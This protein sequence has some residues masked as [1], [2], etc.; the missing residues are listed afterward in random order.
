LPNQS[1]V[2]FKLRHIAAK[3][4]KTRLAGRKIPTIH[5]LATCEIKA[6][7]QILAIAAKSNTSIFLL[8]I[9]TITHNT[10]VN[11]KFSGTK[12]AQ[13][14]RQLFLDNSATAAIVITISPI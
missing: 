3:I 13:I 6:R 4:N 7:E 11:S 14:V 12:I 10:I 9:I 8:G 5:Q 1:E 2:K